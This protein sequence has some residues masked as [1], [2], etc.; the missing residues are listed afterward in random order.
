[1]Q[2]L[3]FALLFFMV[4]A[5]VIGF[6][7]RSK[8][9]R[10]LSAP[11]RKTGE[12]SQNPQG[13][14]DPK[15]ALSCEGTIRPSSAFVAPCSGKACVYWEVKLER[16]YTKTELTENGTKTKKDK[17]TL[18]TKTGGTAFFL[19]DGTGAALI[20]A[21]QGVSCDL[22]KTYE[23][24]QNVIAG[25]AVF[26]TL[27]VVVPHPSGDINS[28]GVTAIERI[29]PADGKLFVL[30]TVKE[31]AITKLT[32]SRKGRDAMLGSTKRNS[33]IGFAA[34]A[35]MLLPG[36]GL[37]IFADPP[38]KAADTCAIV[39]ETPAATPCR[40]KV[41]NDDGVKVNITITKAGTYE[42]E[43][44]APSSVKI[45]FEPRISV[46]DS[47]GKAL[48]TK[49][50]DSVELDLTPGVYTVKLQEAVKGAPARFKG[51]FSFELTVKR[52]S[53][54]AEVTSAALANAPAPSALPS[55]NTNVAKPASAVKPAAAVVKPVA[56]AGD[57]KPVAA[58]AGD[59]KPAAAAGDVKPA[60]GAVTTPA[61]ATDVKPA[62]AAQSALKPNAGAAINAAGP[63][64][65]PVAP[66]V[67]PKPAQPAPP[68]H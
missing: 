49:V 4:V 68:A 36:A 3:G 34:A 13:A 33:T 53:A 31:G 14:A 40:G 21:S 66:A 29:I 44:Q 35:V 30:G 18:F 24:K 63:A 28:T 26:G 42:I 32:A 19:D 25:D 62:T 22:D 56:A 55:G 41:T 20:D 46:N 27:E 1:M 17:E 6:V 48:A 39:D 67:A 64:H 52:T 12:I 16:S 60:T 38:A 37:S 9:K 50:R 58:A 5:L 65:A 2:Y 23:Q 43:A 8:M 15:G 59:V 10:I 57:V 45:P 11:F 51:G 54:A 7:Q 47:T 61:A